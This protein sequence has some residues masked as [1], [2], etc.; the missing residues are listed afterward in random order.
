M[1]TPPALEAALPSGHRVL[2]E[3][4]KANGLRPGGGTG[5]VLQAPGH[6]LGAS[7]GVS[8]RTLRLGLQRRQRWRRYGGA[9]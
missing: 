7:G 1:V 5:G 6:R 9:T 4:A 2:V 8:G 3:D